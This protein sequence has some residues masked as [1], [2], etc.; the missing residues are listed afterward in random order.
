MELQKNRP[1]YPYLAS[2]IIPISVIIFFVLIAKS[3]ID[4]DKIGTWFYSKEGK[5]IIIISAIFA[6]VLVKT[7]IYSF[8]YIINLSALG[9]PLYI[10]TGIVPFLMYLIPVFAFI[11]YLKSVR[12]ADKIELILALVTIIFTSY[13]VMTFVGIWLRGEGMHLIF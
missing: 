8:E 3:Q 5:K 7:L 2:F 4:K 10:S 13:L 1:W 12:K 9:F 6:S 11:F